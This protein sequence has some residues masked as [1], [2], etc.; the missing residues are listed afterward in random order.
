MHYLLSSTTDN[1]KRLFVIERILER[2]RRLLFKQAMLAAFEL[3]AHTRIEA[4][5]SL[6]AESLCEIHQA[7]NRKYYGQDFVVDEALKYECLTY[8]HLYDSFSVYAYATG[9]SA[10][11]ALAKQIIQEG[12][13][14]VERYL[15]FLSSGSSGYGLDLL[16]DAG[17]DLSTPEPIQVALDMFDGYRREF[18]MGLRKLRINK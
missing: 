6:T 18:E 5:E 12:A 1:I 13:P 4:G 9:F 3:E 8:P 7:L 10:A 17:V 16:R 14:A 2:F 15:R 11:L